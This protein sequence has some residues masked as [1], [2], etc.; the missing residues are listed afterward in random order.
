MN[1]TR[2]SFYIAIGS[3]LGLGLSP[4]APGSCGALLGVVYH[5]GV[6]TLVSPN[7]QSLTLG[8]GLL[9][10]MFANHVL[11]PWATEYWK[12]QDPK[13]FVLDEIAGYLVVPLL[14]P[15]GD[16]LKVAFVGFILFRIFDIVKIP[17]ARQID[18]RL[19]G[20]WGIVLDDIV[21]GIYAALSLHFLHWLRIL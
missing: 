15:G 4:F 14:F 21:S 11:T 20:P 2:Q 10:V 7:W 9:I 1:K 5:I 12:S 18:Q 17:P 19:H 16:L 8:I 3:A 13:N 6:S